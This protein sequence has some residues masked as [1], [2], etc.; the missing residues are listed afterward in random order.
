MHKPL[1][2]ICGFYDFVGILLYRNYIDV[3]LVYDVIGSQMIKMMHEKLK[4]IVQGVRKELNEPIVWIGF[5]YLYSEL[6]RK[7]P[8][9]RKTWDK[10]S[11]LTGFDSTL[12]NQS[13][14]A[15]NG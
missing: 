12:S 1:T 14:G 11:L 5:D 8:R 15:K 6:M 3:N 13:S 7:E 10:A 9:L 2:T 4:P